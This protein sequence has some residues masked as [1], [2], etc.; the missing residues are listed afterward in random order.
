MQKPSKPQPPKVSPWVFLQE[1]ITEMRQ[2]VFP[3]RSFVLWM[4]LSVL[5][6]VTILSLFFFGIDH[7][8]SRVIGLLLGLSQVS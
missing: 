7:L 8:I 6:M 1:V 3:K 4:T 2:V 5:V